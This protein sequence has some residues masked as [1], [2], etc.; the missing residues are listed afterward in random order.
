MSRC[1]KGTSSIAKDI[2]VPSQVQRVIATAADLLKMTHLLH[3]LR[4][5]LLERV[6]KLV[7]LSLQ[8]L[9]DAHLVCLLLIEGEH[10]LGLVIILAHLLSV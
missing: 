2:T 6:V 1:T 8:L 5:V 9:S 3:I 4:S 7:L 10:F